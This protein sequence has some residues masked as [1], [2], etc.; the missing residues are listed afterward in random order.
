[1]FVSAGCG[2]NVPGSKDE[3]IG[4]CLACISSSGDGDSAGGGEELLP[5]SFCADAGVVTLNA[6]AWDRTDAAAAKKAAAWRRRDG[7]FFMVKL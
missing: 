7:L 3:A 2:S 1:L 5:S 4:L 6:E